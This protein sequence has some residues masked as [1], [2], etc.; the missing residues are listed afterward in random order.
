MTLEVTPDLLGIARREQEEISKLANWAGYHSRPSITF[1]DILYPPCTVME[2]LKRYDTSKHAQRYVYLRFQV[3]ELLLCRPRGL[4]FQRGVSCC[5]WAPR[6]TLCNPPTN[7]RNQGIPTV[8]IGVVYPLDGIHWVPA[9][10]RNSSPGHHRRAKSGLVGMLSGEFQSSGRGYF[11][12]W[13]GSKP[14]LLLY[15]S[16][17]PRLGPSTLQALGI[18]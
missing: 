14:Y 16:G 9:R 5:L 12:G 6:G 10:T 13:I 1:N 2:Y 3:G 11:R 18:P 4:Y 8:A 17:S 7:S 15:D